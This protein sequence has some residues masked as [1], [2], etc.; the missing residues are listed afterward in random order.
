MG[1]KLVLVSNHME[2][3][4]KAVEEIAESTG[5]NSVHFIHAEL[6]SLDSVREL[7]RSFQDRYQGLHLLVN[8]AAIVR[9]TRN[10]TKD[11]LEEVFEVNYLSHFLLTLLLLETLKNSA[12]S[13]V[14]NV[15]SSVHTHLDIDDLQEERHYDGF[16][17]YGKSKTAL[18]LFT[19]ELARRSA[20]SGVSVNCVHPGAVRTHI[21]DHGGGLAGL[22]IKL[23]RPFVM[24]P[25]KAAKALVYVATSPELEGITGR[26]F[27]KNELRQSSPQTRD[28]ELAGRLWKESL[29]LVGL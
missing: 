6:A 11:G 15:V 24:S 16:R 7:S 9:G 1:A 25:E 14:V 22:G 20:G 28:E 3:G 27:F 5:N 23:I 18:I 4:E 21:G 26:Y 29:H 13:R 2:G 17:S 10:V 8:N 12:P 19:Y